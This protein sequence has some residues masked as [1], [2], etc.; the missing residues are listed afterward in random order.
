M[1]RKTRYDKTV[2]IAVCFA[3]ERRVNCRVQYAYY[4]AFGSL[5]NTQDV[6]NCASDANLM[7]RRLQRKEYLPKPVHRNEK[8]LD[9]MARC[10]LQWITTKVKEI[11]SFAV[12]SDTAVCV[13]VAGGFRVYRW[14][15]L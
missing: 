15:Q 2:C 8:N 10:V 9:H 4:I 7:I 11:F 3:F 1:K 12:C 13:I 5:L 6:E 14:V